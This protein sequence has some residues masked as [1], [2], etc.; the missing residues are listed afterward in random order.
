MISSLLSAFFVSFVICWVI[1]HYTKKVEHIISD[2]FDGP[3]KFHYKATPR[4]GGAGVFLACLILLIT[5]YLK[6]HDKMYL[7]L[8]FSSIPAFLS[9]FTE[10]ITKNIRPLI[11]LLSAGISGGIFIYLTGYYLTGL[12]LFFLDFILKYPVVGIVFTVFAIAGVSNAVNIIDGFNGLASAVSIMIFLSIAY[13]AFKTED[14]FIMSACF[15]YVG[16][17]SGFFIWNY[18]FGKIFLG[19]GGAYF[20]GFTMA[21]LSVSLVVRN[22]DVSPWF[23]FL[24]GIYPIFETIFSMYR[25]KFLNKTD[26]QKPDSN[27]LHQLVYKRVVPHVFNIHRNDKLIQNSATSPFLW[28]L[29][30]MGVFPATIFWKNTK[31]LILI[32]I[33]FCFIYY[34]LY[35]SIVKFRLFRRRRY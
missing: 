12:N 8:L 24:A 19:D 22:P 28:I 14:Y 7:F 35:K 29:C 17:I 31:I 11:R 3:Q 20:T 10:D 33:I 21:A 13:V 27:H 4:I 9:G 25:R 30:S 1:L 23:P 6:T 32:A 5:L 15:V 34:Y 2:T 16:A 18:P 26:I